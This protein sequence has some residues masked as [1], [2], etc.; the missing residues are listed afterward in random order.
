M[1]DKL[2]VHG[3]PKTIDYKID[4]QSYIG[5]EERQAVDQVMTS[6]VLSQYLGCWHPDFYG[7]PRVK[8]FESD[9]SAFFGVEHSV[10]VNSATSG[11]I[12]ALGAIGIE[13]GDEVIVS[14]WTMAASATSI[15]VWGAVP[16]FADIEDKTFNLCAETIERRITPYTKA[17]VVT[18]IFGHPAD[19]EAI[20]KLARARGLKVIEDTAQ[21]P[22]ARYRG[23][24]AGTLADIGV[25]SLNYH[26]H[27]NTGEGG[28]CVT[29]D[30]DLAERMRLIRNHGEAVA[31]DKPMSSLVNIVG[32]NFRLTEL[33]AAIGIEQLKKLARI[34][35]ER[36]AT[37]D[38]LTAGL[39]SLKG[40]EVPYVRSDSTH[41]YYIYPLKVDFTALGVSRTRVAAALRAEGVPVEE[42]YE[43]VHRLPIYQNRIAY[44]SK[45]FPWRSDV[46]RGDVSYQLGICP[47][48]ERLYDSTYLGIELCAARYSDRETRLIVQAFQKVWQQ[49]DQV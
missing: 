34:V 25:F 6:G 24:Y 32:F 19:F 13:P 45:G 3:G 21:A 5:E 27:I 4:Y 12:A 7:G 8:Q 14:P 46:Y 22:G 37:A 18:D 47:T 26:K 29:R 30:A 10:A 15:L 31:K 35:E 49:L 40:V 33:Q 38:G 36:I 23:A 2:A 44:G 41:V 16:V 43:N 48:A 42:F 28:V 1:V 11:L 20:M 17:V 39:K 9:W